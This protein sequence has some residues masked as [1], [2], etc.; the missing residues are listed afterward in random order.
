M[1]KNKG[2]T[3]EELLQEALVPEE[4]QRYK[5]PSNWRWVRLGSVCEVVGGGTPKSSLSEYFEDGDIPWVTPAD[6]SGYTEM[7]IGRGKRNITE[8]GLKNSSARLMPEGTVLLS[9]R[10]PIGYVA[11]ASNEISTNQGFK[12]FLPSKYVDS[13]YLYWYLKLSTSYIDSLASG[14]TFREISGSKCKEIQIPLAPIDEQRRIADKVEILLNKINQAKQ[15]IE[16]AEETF[17]LRRAAILDKAFRGE[18]TLKWR[19]AK[20]EQGDTVENLLSL[21]TN[22]R[23]RK[24]KKTS[25][26]LKNNVL[27][28]DFPDTWR[29]VKIEDLFNIVGGGTPSKSVIEYWTGDIPWVTPKDMKTLL[30]NSSLDKISREAINKSSVNLVKKGSVALVVRSGILQRT[31]PVALL[32]QGST[33]N[34]DMKVFDSGIEDVNRYFMWYI[35]AYEKLL[36]KEY[37]KSGTTVN[38]IENDKFKK[39]L[40]PL[41]PLSEIKEILEIIEILL[42]KQD[43]VNK[44]LQ[45]SEDMEI[46]KQSILS[47][48]FRGELGTNDYIEESSLHSIEKIHN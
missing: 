7:F 40:I 13:K 38:S 12:S 16:E 1:S 5:V 10:A 4:E 31:L 27:N 24:N 2:K 41:P 11:I 39:H 47:K 30:V 33:V 6:L 42:G 48:A 3:A 8:L 9:S 36:L 46:L 26:H 20:L 43:E 45:T 19:R 32:M 37:T 29:M 17:E 22:M 25:E 28:A 35:V 15:L 18:L 23:L 14:T 44:K 34:Q 21:I